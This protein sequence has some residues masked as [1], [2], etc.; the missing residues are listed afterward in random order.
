MPAGPAAVVGVELAEPTEPEE[1]LGHLV[2]LFSHFVLAETVILLCNRHTGDFYLSIN[3]SEWRNLCVN[4][5]D[6]VVND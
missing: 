2:V 4:M 3:F 1:L 6:D 5:A